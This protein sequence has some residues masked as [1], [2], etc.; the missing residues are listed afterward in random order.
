MK[1][2]APDLRTMTRDDLR[3]YLRS[4]AVVSLETAGRCLNVSR[5]AAYRA[6]GDGTNGTIRTLR[7]GARRLVVPSRWLERAL[8][9]DEGDGAA[10]GACH[11]CPP[12][13]SP[14][15]G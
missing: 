5:P 3:T 13:A 7:I 9:L 11:E 1:P 8:M 10:C 14:R 4:V 6:A 15:E 12:S 2:T